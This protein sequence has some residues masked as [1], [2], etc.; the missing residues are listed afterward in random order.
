ME[1]KFQVWEKV[2]QWQLREMT[3]EARDKDEVR[4]K[5][6]LLQMTGEYDAVGIS[7]GSL[8][9]AR[10]ID[11]IEFNLPDDMKIQKIEV[12]TQTTISDFTDQEID[13]TYEETYRNF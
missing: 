8:L 5:A 2:S 10:D 6:Y 13:C 4:D 9:Q 11:D 3:V 7:R 1:Y 12:G